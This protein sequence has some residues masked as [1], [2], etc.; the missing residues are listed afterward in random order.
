[1][2]FADGRSSHHRPAADGGT[3][4]VN[5]SNQRPGDSMGDKSPKAKDR[6]KKQDAKEKSQKV[7]TAALKAAANQAVPSNTRK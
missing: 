5:Q 2:S 7:A 1:M 4:I 3:V 6:Q